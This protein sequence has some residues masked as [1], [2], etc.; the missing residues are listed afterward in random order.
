[1]LYLL[2]LSP[3]IGLIIVLLAS[4]P[5]KDKLQ[6]LLISTA[7]LT[8][9]MMLS[10]LLTRCLGYES[11]V[12]DYETWGGWV[13]SAEYYE[14]WN[15]YIH[16]T[17]T[18]TVGTGKNQRTETYDCSY[19]RYH[20]PRY[21]AYTS[22]NESIYISKDSWV[23]LDAKFGNT[24]KHDMHR[25]YHTIDGD[26]YKAVWRGDEPAY[27]RVFTEYQYVNKVQYSTGV[28]HF[29]KVDPVGLYKYPEHNMWDS[30]AVLGIYSGSTE[31]D[32]ILQKYNSKNGASKQVKLY[33]LL[34]NDDIQKAFDQR[35]LWR[36]GNK[37]EFV[38]CVG[39]KNNKVSWVSHFCWSPDG[40]A[41][42]DKIGI[43]M[44][45]WVGKDVN[46]VSMSNDLMSLTNE[47]WRR[48]PFEEFKYL[49]VQ[50][51]KAVSITVITL[52]SLSFIGLLVLGLTDVELGGTKTGFRRKLQSY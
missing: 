29:D 37:N 25:H 8:V 9:F 45:D 3:I 52:S 17:C 5:E 6:G 19:V 47:N 20:P 44:R 22:N 14:E 11:M 1:M 13:T 15:E 38:L 43:E 42:N 2:S 31:A 34:F 32:A 12:T 39:V 46:L 26:M 33:M 48:K 4:R 18:R 35:S 30:K 49:D 28:F 41:G 23:I 10:T 36:G 7:G 24:H 51:P 21:L 50:T 27:T 40:Y 16:Q